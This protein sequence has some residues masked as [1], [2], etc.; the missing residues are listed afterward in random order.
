LP[1]HEL[2]TSAADAGA[3]LDLFVARALSLP[4]ARVKALIEERAVRVNGRVARKGDTLTEGLTVTVMLAEALPAMVPEPTAPLEILYSDASLVFID[5]RAWTPAHPLEPGEVG[6]VAN[7]LVARFPEC[8]LASEEPREA[9][10]C[11][12][13]DTETS[14][15]LLAAR[16]PEAWKAMRRAFT[17]R[18]VD[19]RY[20]ALVIGPLADEGEIDLPLRHPA[21]RTDRME[22]AAA[23]GPGSREAYTTFRTLARAGEATLVE[24]K[25]ETG[26]LHQ[27]RAHL[28]AIG[29]PIVG[30]TLYGGRTDTALGRFFLHAKALGVTHPATG[31][32]LRVESPLPPELIAALARHRF[33]PEVALGH[34]AAG[35]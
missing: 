5:K 19:K 22:P 34:A 23:G 26:V 9:G 14:G 11:H 7:A 21:R 15:V 27:V 17:E 29:A 4:R 35:C 10:L 12:R 3:R 6:T 31:A 1:N 28:A 8:A 16:T 32:S 25:I 18:H 33:S 13:L 30:D 20:W 2:K 24:A